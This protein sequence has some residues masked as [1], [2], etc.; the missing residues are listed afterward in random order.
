MNNHYGFAIL[1]V[2]SV[3]GCARSISPIESQ[4]N[5]SIDGKLVQYSPNQKFNLQLDL[6]FDSGYQWDI[7]LTDSNVVH[8]D[9]TSYRP[10]SGN[11]NQTGG[12]AIETF[13]FCTRNA[14]Q[15]AVTLVEHRGW[16]H[17]VPAIDSLTF[18]VN[19]IQ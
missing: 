11:Y 12:L 2:I 7:S 5:S 15:S 16:E 8:V 1:V 10:K 19:V 14:G 18:T 17:G 9:S 13:Y 3:V 6:N 4:W